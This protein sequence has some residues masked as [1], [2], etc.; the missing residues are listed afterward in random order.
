M[1]THEAKNYKRPTMQDSHKHPQRSLGLRVGD[2][3]EVRSRQEIL[4]TLDEQAR[5]DALPFMPEM[6]EYCGRRFKVF[7]S[8]HKTC[9]TIE[10]MGARKLERTVHLQELRCSGKSHGGCQA[11]CLLFWKEAWLKKVDSNADSAPAASAANA[12]CS[13]RQLLAAA[14]RTEPT[15]SDAG[16]GEVVYTCQA[17]ELNRASSVLPWW[18]LRQYV[19]DVATGNVKASAL[20]AALLFRLFRILLRIGAYRAL[21]RAYD[22]M[23]KRR[24]GAPYPFRTGSCEKTPDQRLDLQSGELV[25]AKSQE[26]ILRTVNRRNRNRGLSFDEEMVRFCGGTYR[27]LRRVERIINERSGKM[28]TLKGDCVILA[29]VTCQS[30]FKDQR[31]FCPRAIFP[32]WREIWLKRVAPGEGVVAPEISE[33]RAAR[34]DEA[35]ANR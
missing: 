12:G 2:T 24:G 9:D 33:V 1:R 23:Q 10:F 6:L 13:E 20:L 29:G 5:L 16:E 18:D 4:A 26:E 15:G 22:A 3:V 35:P 31:L 34:A 19:Q 14:Q 25:Q 27:V 32:Y 17:T 30:Q 28:M 7:K 11:G 21:V 8:A